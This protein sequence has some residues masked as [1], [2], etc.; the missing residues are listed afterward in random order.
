MTSTRSLEMKERNQG[1]RFR[2]RLFVQH[3]AILCYF[4]SVPTSEKKAIQE[5]VKIESSSTV[6]SFVIV[7]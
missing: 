3:T 5:K 2:I 1:N 4:P 6:V 7:R